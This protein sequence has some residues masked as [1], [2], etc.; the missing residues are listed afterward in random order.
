MA[1]YEAREEKLLGKIADRL[2]TLDETLAK[3]E[4][5]DS[6]VKHFFEQEKAL[7]EIRVITRKENRINRDEDKAEEK[8]EKQMSDWISGQMK[9]VDDIDKRI[10]TLDATLAKLD[11]DKDSK[12]KSYLEQ[13][14]A[15]EEIKKILKDSDKL[16]K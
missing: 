5:T 8:D 10:D 6:K 13:K 7:H 16:E 1:D 3:M 9:L 11:E 2:N 12:V 4:D 14:K 15:I